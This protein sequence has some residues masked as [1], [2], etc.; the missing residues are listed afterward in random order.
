MS[1][2][3]SHETTGKSGRTERDDEARLVARIQSGEPEAFESL[4]REHAAPLATLAYT[5]L[6]SRDDA[7]DVVQSL[8]VWLW[9]NR[10][11]F[12]PEH[13]VRAYLFGAVRKRS[14]NRLRDTSTHDR[15]LR[16]LSTQTVAEVPPADAALEASQLRAI[17]EQSVATM[18]PRCRE[19]F[20]LVRTSRLSHAEVAAILGI[21]P[22]TVEVHMGRALAIL[23][24]RLGP[25]FER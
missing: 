24:T 21:A 9:A 4:F 12:N 5:L 13:G 10:H 6:Q 16:E 17:V 20:T 3:A 1:D 2:H 25:H 11:S 15:A 23:R 18:P 22:K 8:F 14:L 19:V 7:E